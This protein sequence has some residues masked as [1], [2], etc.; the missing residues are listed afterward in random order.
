MDVWVPFTRVQPATEVVLLR[1]THRRW[2]IA[3]EDGY[4]EFWRHRWAGQRGFVNLEH[5][6][7][8]WPGAMEAMWVCSEPWCAYGYDPNDLFA[9]H[10]HTLFPY[11]GCVKIGAALI[12][13]TPHMWDGP[14]ARWD[15]LDKHLA[16]RAREAGFD[17]HQHWPPV[18]NANPVLVGRRDA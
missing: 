11:L 8:P 17:V 10:A 1:V 14:P 4:W 13:G 18:V 9:D 12:A 6:V 16:G 3:G 15:E 2:P 5:D 7:V